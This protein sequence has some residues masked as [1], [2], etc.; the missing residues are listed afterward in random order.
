MTLSWH[1]AQFDSEN[2][3]IFSR[4]RQATSEDILEEEK[5]KVE[6]FNC[7]GKKRETLLSSTRIK[8]KKKK[9]K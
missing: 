8:K 4:K 6:I 9:E 5:I 1:R 3:V 2:R 7:V